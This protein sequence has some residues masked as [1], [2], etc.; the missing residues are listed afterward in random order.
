M[1]PPGRARNH[2]L[3]VESTGREIRVATWLT[4]GWIDAAMILGWMVLVTAIGLRVWRSGGGR[5]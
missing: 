3:A 4:S 2:S 5:D 1:I